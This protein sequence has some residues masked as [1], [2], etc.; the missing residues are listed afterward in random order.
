MKF[1]LS[2]LF[3]LLVSLSVFGEE[4]KLYG[5]VKERATGVTLPYAS[6][7]CDATTKGTLT[8]EK[9][10]YELVLQDGEYLV[11]VEF[12]GYK[13]VSK[14]LTISGKDKRVDFVLDTDYEDLEE[15]MVSRHRP[16]ENVAMPTLGIQRVDGLTMKRMPSLMGEVDV[17]KVIQLLPGVQSAA[18]GT[19][20]FSV[21]GGK[22]D[23]NLIMLD[24][25]SLYNASHMMGFFSIFNNDVVSEATLL[26]GDIPAQ[27][28]GRLSSVLKVDTKEGFP[29]KI[30]GSGGV[31][32]ISSRLML[33]VPIISNKT[34][35]LVAGRRT[36]A[37]LFLP[38]SGNESLKGTRLFFYDMNAK[39]SHKINER[40][41]LFWSGYLG[42][43]KMGLKDK[44][45]LKFGNTNTTLR[46]N[47]KWSENASSNL[48]VIG[49]KYDYNIDVYIAPYEC[50]IDAG[51]KDWSL[52]YDWKTKTGDGGLLSM[53]L[54]STI[55]RYNQGSLS[56]PEKA[57]IYYN[58]FE[59]QKLEVRKALEHG[60]YASYEKD[61]TKNFLVKFGLRLSMFQNIGKERFYLMDSH[62]KCVDTIDYGKGEIFN[63]EFHA[64]PRLGMMYRLTPT[65]SLKAA[66]T[67]TVQYAQVASNSTGGL[68]FDIWFP[69]SI[70]VKPQLC[71]QWSA[72]YFRNFSN[73]KYETSAEVFYK[74]MRNVIDFCDNA[75]IYGNEKIDG[76]I[77]TGNGFAYG[78]EVM[79]KKSSGRLT[80]WLSYTYAHSY[81]TIE[82]IN[83]GERYRSPF[84]RPHNL[85]AVLSFDITKRLNASANWVLMSGQP[86]TNPYGKYTVENTSY[87]IYTGYRNQSNYPSYHRLDLSL[88]WKTK[89]KKKW[90]S[91]WNL[92]LY[93]A[94]AR[95]NT[96]AVLFTPEGDNSISTTK[97]YLF[98][99]VPSI[100]YNFKF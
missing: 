16:D 15:V 5:T 56:T 50:A 63:T 9:G 79:L 19:S 51:T 65:S 58:L 100:S 91:D 32:L 14:K 95:H 66:Y 59:E 70:N 57:Q 29:S 3:L 45:G 2:A 23:Q 74:R 53:G 20:G 83:F 17:I 46:W 67:R 77:R 37:D 76:E 99:I 1:K 54:S 90:E 13:T 38:L 82:E 97:L 80:G 41:K 75:D 72:G 48:S 12:V 24:E 84:D 36:Y 69:T 98:S 73:N 8:N 55:H 30:H 68:P 39:L 62:H 18:E 33:D 71:N 49:T 86:C 28:G 93:N 4:H 21:R 64:E 60:L 87:A 89:K 11:M 40:N 78:L 92:S 96:W 7:S 47:H 85:T 42:T 44:L 35:L 88:T 6:I 25:A 27:Y 10:Y 34:S 22:A 61:F 31:G 81:Q 94:Y 52:L 26:K 43:D